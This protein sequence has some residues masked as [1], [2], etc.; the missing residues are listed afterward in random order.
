MYCMSVIPAGPPTHCTE[1]KERGPDCDFVDK[2]HIIQCLL[3]TVV[4]SGY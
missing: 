2:K 3:D 1:V 4:N